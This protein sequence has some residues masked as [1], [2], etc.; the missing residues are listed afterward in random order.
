MCGCILQMT[1]GLSCKTHSSSLIFQKPWSLFRLTLCNIDHSDLLSHLVSFCFT[2]LRISIQ[3]VSHRSHNCQNHSNLDTMNSISSESLDRL[4]FMSSIVPCCFLLCWSFTDFQ[5]FC[6][7][8]VIS[9]PRQNIFLQPFWSWLH[10]FLCKALNFPLYSWW[11]LIKSQFFHDISP[12]V[13]KIRNERHD[14]SHTKNLFVWWWILRF[15]W[16]HHTVK[17]L[18]TIQDS[19]LLSIKNVLLEVKDQYS[20]IF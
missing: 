17:F 7:F 6:R 11:N 19:S 3:L 5:P 14:W 10:Q 8:W 1:V 16:T 13:N 9:K 18:G 15:P 12:G 2:A 20:R 4:D